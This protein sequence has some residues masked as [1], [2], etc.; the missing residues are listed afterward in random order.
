MKASFRWICGRRKSYSQ[1]Q[2]SE[3]T[4]GEFSRIPMVGAQPAELGA[5]KSTRLL[6]KRGRVLVHDLPGT[7]LLPR[8]QT[9]I[10]REGDVVVVSLAG[11]TVA[12]KGV[13]KDQAGEE[14]R[15]AAYKEETTEGEEDENETPKATAHGMTHAR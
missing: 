11:T 1:I 8:I 15:A 7:N 3:R 2:P 10:E 5:R 14:E 6:Q 9:A 4:E 12:G 13:A